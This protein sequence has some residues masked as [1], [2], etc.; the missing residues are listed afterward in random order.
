MR[1]GGRAAGVPLRQRRDPPLA[2]L[3]GP[4]VHL[5]TGVP[6]A[7]EPGEDQPVADLRVGLP[8]LDRVHEDVV[9]VDEPLP[10]VRDPP[11]RRVGEGH[12][13]GALGGVEPLGA[14]LPGVAGEL[15]HPVGREEHQPP[16][17][18]L[19]GHC[20]GLLGE[21][22]PGARD[23]EAVAVEQVGAVVHDHGFD[24]QRHGE[25][26]VLERGQSER[27]RQ[28]LAAQALAHQVGD[29]ASDSVDGV[30]RDLRILDGG[31]VGRVARPGGVAELGVTAL[32]AGGDLLEVD[33]DGAVCAVEGVDH[34]LAAA[35]GGPE[36][37]ARGGSG[38]GRRC[39]VPPAAGA[40]GSCQGYG[41]HRGEHG[42]TALSS[43]HGASRG[44]C[45]SAG[46]RPRLFG[47]RES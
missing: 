31:D 22:V 1:A 18:C 7:A 25:H 27:L 40:H 26:A 33:L 37:D 19:A 32:P 23:V 39:P 28:Q 8:A 5:R 21:L 3:P 35:Q 34:L 13:P 10:V 42:P 11:G 14:R 20:R 43:G 6:R 9:A 16:V 12:V 30:P 4:R 38:A 29:V 17:R 15:R 46:V 44:S 2:L 47:T 41:G 36:G 24:V 45:V